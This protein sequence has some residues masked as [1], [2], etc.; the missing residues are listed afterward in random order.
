[1]LTAVDIDD[2]L[3]DYTSSL[4][5]FYNK[6]YNTSLVRNDF[7]SYNFWEVWGHER[8]SHRKS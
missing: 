4:A 2:T 5:E 1:M 7:Y 8:R 6:K 3:G